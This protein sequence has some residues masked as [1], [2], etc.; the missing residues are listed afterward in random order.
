[1]RNGLERGSEIVLRKC[2]DLKRGEK[3]LVVT[4]DE[5]MNIGRALYHKAIDLGSDAVLA[6]IRPRE[7]S[8]QE[9]PELISQ[10]MQNADVVLCPTSKSLTHTNA[11]L[12]AV[13]AGARI[14][15]M[16]GITE[17]MFCKGPISADYMEVEQITVK[18]AEMLSNAK[19]CRVLTGGKYELI[20]GLEG[21][22]GVASTGVY[23]EKGA[24]GNLPSGE[25]YIAPVEDRAEGEFLVDGSIVG[26][27]QLR[28]PVVLRLQ[29]GRIADIKGSLGAAVDKAIPDNIL[30]RTIGELGIGTNPMARLTGVIL[31]DEKIYGS[32]HIAFGTNITFGGSIKA[33]SHI[34]CV[35]LKPT[36]YIDEV[37]VIEEGN[38]MISV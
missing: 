7:V 16:P 4:D 31:E 15:T 36:V 17:E 32:V 24:S 27:G 20:M 30:S 14:A 11:R 12:E 10:A 6:V 23:R 13:K 5:K 35:T 34:D 26:I 18:L 29:K 2:L 38:L 37:P 28:D 1:M 22:R 19:Q 9:P 33:P 3:V 8:G 21:R 25:A